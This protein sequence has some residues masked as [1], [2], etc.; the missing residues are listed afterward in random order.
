M[1]KRWVGIVAL[2][3]PTSCTPSPC[4]SCPAAPPYIQ[5][6]SGGDDGDGDGD[7][8]GGVPGRW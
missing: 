1:S 4:L 3:R 8:D 6:R 7:G 2:I 5:H